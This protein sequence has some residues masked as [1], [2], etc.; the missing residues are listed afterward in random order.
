MSL[1]ILF[2]LLFYFYREL[3]TYIQILYT[4]GRSVMNSKFR[5]V[6]MFLLTYNGTVKW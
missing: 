3:I 5:I 2:T 4:L 6:E 1:V